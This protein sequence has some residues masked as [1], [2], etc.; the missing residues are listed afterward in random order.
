M[1]LRLAAAVALG[2]LLFAAGALAWLPGLRGALV[3]RLPPRLRIALASL[4]HGVA[5]DH[6]VRIAAADGVRLATSVYLPRGVAGPLPTILI[7]MPYHRLHYGEGYWNAIDFA[8]HGYAAVVQ[9]L[10]GTGD[11]EGT[12]LPWRDAAEDG[13][14]TLD[15]I[16]R[17]SWSNGKVGTFGCSALGETQYVLARLNHPAHRAMTPSGAGGG[18]GSALGQ[19]GYFGLFEG[20]VFQLASGFGWFVDKGTYDPKAPPA[21]AYDRAT[22]LREL[23]LATLV[24]KV[25]PAPNGYA[26]LLATPLAHPRWAEWGYWSDAD[27]T[28]VPALAINTW[29]DQTLGGTLALAEVWRRQG[30]PQTVVIAPGNHCGHRASA[31][32]PRF[33]Q[34]SVT[35][36]AHPWD[37]WTLRWFDRWLK[38]KAE[39]T[40]GWPAYR[41][42]M[43]VENRWHSADRW[44]P[45][46]AQALRWYLG[47]GHGANGRAGDGTLTP[48][49]APPVASAAAAAADTYRYDPNDPVPSRGGP[50]CCTGDPNATA[51]PA[52]QADVEARPDVLV[53]TSEPLTQDLR[54][55]G[56]LV[57]HLA[58]SSDAPDTDVVARLVHVRP[59]GLATNIQE[60]ALRLRYRESFT[61]PRLL[62][63]GEVVR[64]NVDM[65]AIAYMVPRGH[66]LRLQVT[67]SSF[68]RLERNLNT[69]APNNAEETRMRV[70][71]NRV[72]HTPEQPSWVELQ[73]LREARP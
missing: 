35:G 59:D 32:A 43:L 65:R 37:D 15:W 49:D 8:R 64:A 12:L 13:A 70:A 58:F 5:V 62:R 16:T 48:G 50:L 51:G 10:R 39:A 66:R 40:A 28:S 42:F 4:P 6:D 20:G 30:V 73:V 2:L 46:E 63:E 9:D 52:D 24:E 19:Y 22:H 54:I 38:D 36:A 53:Y 72:H 27:R 61:V 67:S 29:G 71:T 1:S 44:P 18:I 47:S 56:P 55:A 31:V 7:R 3:E 69:G 34:L 23:P 14:A 33:G 11:S 26:D 57:A 60:G 21:R 41:Y 17:Q 25:R 45:T 68:P